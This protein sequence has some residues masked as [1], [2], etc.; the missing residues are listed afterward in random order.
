MDTSKSDQQASNISPDWLSNLSKEKMSRTFRETYWSE[1]EVVGVG[2]LKGGG[3]V[4]IDAGRRHLRHV[5]TP[6]P[7][8]TR[9]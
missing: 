8:Q 1:L 4:Y 3:G 7:R 2:R 6:L 9:H 5:V